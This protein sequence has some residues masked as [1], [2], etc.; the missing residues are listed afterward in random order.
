MR[1][2]TKTRRA[3]APES[4]RRRT[5]L[6][7]AIDVFARKGYHGT[8]MSDVSREAGVAYG[9]VYH[10][11][12]S[13]DALLTSVFELAW[14]GFVTR[15]REAAEGGSHVSDRIR[16]MVTVGFD[17]YRVD[18]NGVRVVLLEIARGPATS[19]LNRQSAFGEVT[20]I[21][22]GVFDRARR[23]GELKADVD[24]KL[25][26]AMLFG[27]LESLL[28]QFVLG[29]ADPHDDPTLERAKHQLSETFL[30]GVLL[31]GHKDSHRAL[32]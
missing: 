29:Q 30:S 3:A 14:S 9:L 22:E 27:A 26:A 13:K 12:Q 10:Y 24:P 4:D 28:T 8:R 2:K 21:A 17:A 23:E 16:A 19:K 32:A 7:A 6:R 31:E 20:E 15:V 18:A 25:C 11:F 5:I 1:G